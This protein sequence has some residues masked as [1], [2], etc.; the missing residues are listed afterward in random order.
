MRWVVRIA[1]WMK[2]PIGWLLTLLFE[3]VY[4]KIKAY[5]EARKKQKEDHEKNKELAQKEVEPLREANTADEV[6]KATD[7][8]LSNF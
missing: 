3:F 7:D 1:G 5:V 2:G 6:D 4:S 8:A